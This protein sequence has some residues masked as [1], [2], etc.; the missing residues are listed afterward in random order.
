MT[1]AKR[2]KIWP[3]VM[4]SKMYKVY[5]ISDLGY[6]HG[7]I[8]WSRA[9]QNYWLVKCHCQDEAQLYRSDQLDLDHCPECKAPGE[10][11]TEPWPGEESTQGTPTGQ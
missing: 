5:D 10:I 1:K 9:K 3:V 4:R 11:A 8:H 2:T 6:S 7:P